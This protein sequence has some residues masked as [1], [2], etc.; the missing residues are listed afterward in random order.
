MKSL[1]L[2]VLTWG[3]LLLPGMAIADSPTK[4]FTDKFPIAQCQFQNTG[5][6]P[7]FMLHINRELHLN[8]W[9]CFAD[10]KCDDFEELVIRVLPETRMITFKLEGKMMTVDTRVVEKYETVDGEFARRSRNFLSVCQETQDVYYFGED[11]LLAEGSHPGQWVAGVDGALPGM[12]FPGGAFLLGTRY[13]QKIAPKAKALDRAEHMEM[14][15][16]IT[17]PA[18]TF[19]NCVKIEETTPM[20]QQVRSVK[21][22]CE[23]IGLVTDGDLELVRI[24]P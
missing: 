8:N 7:Y 5:D 20:D 21:Q 16:K 4:E 1:P 24:D 17:I 6:H 18:G 22:Y 12:I 23:G 15:L 11:V 10:G 3:I 9:Q 2:W 14:G 13:Y 19:G